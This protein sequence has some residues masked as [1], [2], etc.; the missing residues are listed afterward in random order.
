MEWFVD[1]YDEFRMRT[2][3]GRVSEEE[4][5]KDVD[6]ICDV[7]DLHEGAKVLDL[8]CGTGRHS[9]ELARRGYLSTGIELNPGYL[10]L[11]KQSSKGIANA[12]KFIQGDVRYVDFGEG[13]DAV[14]VMFQSFGYFADSEDKSVLS[15]IFDSLKPKGRFLIEI[16]NRDW[17]LKNFREIQKT[18]IDGIQVIEKREFDVLT[19]RNNFIIQRYENDGVVT[20]RGSWRMYSAHEM[21]NILEG[22]GFRLVGG[23]ANLE[24]EPLTI[25]TRL[26]RMV[27]EK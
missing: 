7:L 16:L 20:K 2:G 6:F 8:F 26:M 21:K 9:L 19:S 13:Y 1:L 14:I 5:R 24:K 10:E 4:T 11:G 23:F 18:E 27:F 25:N 17:I 3:F 22:I 15:K 12:P